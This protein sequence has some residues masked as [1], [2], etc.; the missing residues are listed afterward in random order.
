MYP[1]AVAQRLQ[2]NKSSSKAYSSAAL[3]DTR[4]RREPLL[5]DIHTGNGVFVRSC[6][7][8][9]HSLNGWKVDWPM[10]RE[11][12]IWFSQKSANTAPFQSKTFR[13]VNYLLNGERWKF[14][15]LKLFT[16]Y[17]RAFVYL[18]LEA[19]TVHPNYL[20]VLVNVYIQELTLSLWY[21]W[22]AVRR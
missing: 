20:V 13:F 21:L 7:S 8:T 4:H 9:L 16:F 17:Q 1:E 15:H 2:W 3:G 12:W 11:H 22:W 6:C 18:S 19:N 10:T 14:Y 5:C